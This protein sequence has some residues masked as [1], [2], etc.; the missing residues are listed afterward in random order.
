METFDLLEFKSID[1][2]RSNGLCILQYTVT[3]VESARDIIE[4]IPVIL[5]NLTF[6]KIS[7]LNHIFIIKMSPK[8]YEM[9]NDLCVN[10]T[11]NYVYGLPISV[12][13]MVK[14]FPQVIVDINTTSENTIDIYDVGDPYAELYQLNIGEHA[15][16]L[17]KK[18]VSEKKL[19]T[20]HVLLRIHPAYQTYFSDYYDDTKKYFNDPDNPQRFVEMA[21]I[22]DRYAKD[23]QIQFDR[24]IATNRFKLSLLSSAD[25]VRKEKD[26]IKSFYHNESLT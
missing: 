9:V 2:K 10:G 19:S 24:W 14:A 6:T 16:Y 5:S 22:K 13:I 4:N 23:V 21:N 1:G 3:D 17:L 25:N 8:T 20:D 18:W 12:P 15:R 11:P 7:D 26:C